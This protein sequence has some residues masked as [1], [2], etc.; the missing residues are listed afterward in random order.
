MQTTQTKQPMT[1]WPFPTC[2]N[3]RTVESQALLDK[4]RHYVTKPDL[5]DVEDALL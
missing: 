3:E 2:N 4:K 5:S 1:N